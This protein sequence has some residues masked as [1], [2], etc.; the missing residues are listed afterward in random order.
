MKIIF[1]S[2]S[3]LLELDEDKQIVYKT[4][5]GDKDRTLSPGWFTS[6]RTIAKI[7]TNHVR[8]LNQ[9]DNYTFAMK[10]IPNIL[11]NLENVL[12]NPYYYPWLNKQFIIRAT[13]AF[14]QANNVGLEYSA[15]FDNNMYFLHT[16]LKLANMLVTTDMKIILIDP[17]SYRWVPNL[18]WMEKYSMNQVNLQF[19]LQRYFNHKNV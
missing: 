12:K 5:K 17:D 14:C 4:L 7:A 3:S 10:Y 8:V 13:L 19:C 9:V 16:D 15:K 18:D 11:D 1:E 2:P 6:Y